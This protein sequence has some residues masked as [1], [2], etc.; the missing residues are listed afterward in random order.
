MSANLSN[1]SYI[2]SPYQ[3]LQSWAAQLV[4]LAKHRGVHPDKLLKGTR[5][6]YQDFAA[7]TAS[8]SVEQFYRLQENC[9]QF[10]NQHQ[11]S[12]LLGRKLLNHNPLYSA[13]SQ[14]ESLRTLQKLL[15]RTP[16]HGFNLFN[17]EHKYHQGRHYFIINLSFGA[18]NAAV[19][20]FCCELFASFIAATCKWRIGNNSDL[21]FS[22]PY[23]QPSHIE[24]YQTNLQANC[25]FSQQ[26][27]MV[28]ISDEL[29]NK[30]LI[31]SCPSLLL[32]S[33]A[34]IKQHPLPAA[35]WLQLVRNHIG[36][37]PQQNLETVA[38]HFAMSPATFKRKLKQ[39]H[40]RFS[41]LQDCINRQTA[42][43]NIAT[44]AQSNETLAGELNFSD[45]TNFRRAFKRWTGTT[46]SQ[47]RELI[48]EH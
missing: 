8:I 11:L 6:F 43:F 41:A 9:R 37:Q 1:S 24:Q 28:S 38:Q 45:L 15:T 16:L 14:A 5:L 21:C 10:D 19:E 33:L 18:I 4:D 42:V 13:F 40:T 7:G 44:L 26:L 47:L 2:D 12:F 23:A 22:F 29:Y 39:H 27:F 32:Q 30:H 25:K 17:A 3:G 48:N 34:T 20:Q 31:D 36:A 35:S 46:P